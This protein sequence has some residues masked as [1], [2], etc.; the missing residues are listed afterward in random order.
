MIRLKE[1]GKKAPDFSGD[2]RRNASGFSLNGVGYAVGGYQDK[3]GMNFQE[4]WALVTDQDVADQDDDDGGGNDSKDSNTVD[5][6]YALQ[7]DLD[8]KAYPVPVRPGNKL[9]LEFEGNEDLSLQL[10]LFNTKGYRAKTSKRIAPS[11]DRESIHIPSDL[12][13]GVY[14]VRVRNGKGQKKTRKIL[15]KE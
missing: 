12:E 11:T 9:Y 14:Y 2:L 13:G 4:L 15:I 1:H 7:K 5:S 3:S 8:M 10:D 6:T